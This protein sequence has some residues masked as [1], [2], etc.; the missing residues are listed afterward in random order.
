MSFAS[1]RFP[2]PYELAQVMV[3][4]LKLTEQA[5]SGNPMGT[6]WGNMSWAHA[7]SRDLI[8]WTPYGN[9]PALKPDQAYDREG[10]FTGCLIPSGPQGEKNVMTIIYTSVCDPKIHWTLDY[11]RG[12]ETLSMA[13]SRDGGLSWQKYTENPLLDGPPKGFKVS[14]QPNMPSR[15]H[16]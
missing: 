14:V 8:N 9:Q 11:R 5:A 4:I 12:S 10:V 3:E 7:V 2:F 1:V 16:R 15:Q 13:T 6:E